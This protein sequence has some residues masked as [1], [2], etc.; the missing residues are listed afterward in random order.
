MARIRTFLSYRTTNSRSVRLIAAWLEHNGLEVW[1]AERRIGLDQQFDV[2]SIRDTL[3]R[4]VSSCSHFLVVT[5]ADYLASDW[6]GLEADLIQHRTQGDRSAVIEIALPPDVAVHDRFRFLAERGVGR[7]DLPPATVPDFKAIE[8]AMRRQG[9]PLPEVMR[10][11]VVPAGHP[12]GTTFETPFGIDVPL[13]GWRHADEDLPTSTVSSDGTTLE[14]QEFRR[15]EPIV[16]VAFASFLTHG[17]SD[18][19][20]RP[21]FGDADERQVRDWAMRSVPERFSE[22]INRASFHGVHL[23]FMWG[24]AQLGLTYTLE[25]LHADRGRVAFREHWCNVASA[26]GGRDLEVKLKFVVH[27]GLQRLN[28]LSP[29][30][31][32]HLRVL[33]ATLASRLGSVPAGDALASSSSAT[34]TELPPA[35]RRDYVVFDAVPPAESLGASYQLRRAVRWLTGY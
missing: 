11:T 12:F 15:S 10:G 25:R 23:D 18:E 24:R 14:I 28:A 17:E 8:T 6:C 13:H 29:L 1:F 33:E 31:E 2:P 7:L 22:P 35:L 4:A 32:F 16:A 5:N 34:P 20:P 9:W 27:G 26:D 30:F 19:R 21:R 3:R